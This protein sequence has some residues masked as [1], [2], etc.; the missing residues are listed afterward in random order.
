[1]EITIA[2]L[3]KAMREDGGT[4]FLVD[5]FPRKMDQA[6]KFEETVSISLRKT[7]STWKLTNSFP[8]RIVVVIT[9]A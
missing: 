2:L 4:R 3:E 6:V 5:G 1:M 7:T 8:T 9:C